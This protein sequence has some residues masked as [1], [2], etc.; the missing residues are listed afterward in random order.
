M[1]KKYNFDPTNPTNRYSFEIYDTDISIINGI[2]RVIISDIQVP[3][4]IG[5]N[6]PTVEIIKSNGPLHN[7]YLI[8]RIGLIPICLKENEID[9][10]EDN[11]IE[12]ELNVENKGTNILNVTTNDITVK[13]NNVSLNKKELNEMFYPN[14]ISNDYILI[15]RLRHNEYLHFKANVVK[16]NGKYNASFN[17]V[18]LA[19]FSY[20]ID[21]SKITKDTSI[22]DKERN[23]YTDEYGECNAVLFEIES[24]N[25]YITPK[26]LLNKSFDI[27]ISKLYNIINY[28]KTDN[29]IIN[30]YN[31]LENTYEITI[32]N[33][34]DTIGNII[35]SF[36]HN[37]FVRKNENVL[38]N[39][40]CTYCGYICPHPLKTILQIRFTLPEQTN[41]KV[42]IDFLEYNCVSIIELLQNIKSEWNIFV[43]DK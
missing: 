42:F 37:K 16:K 6:E 13:K 15:T 7:E 28:I 21:D 8:H 3:G 32:D 40:T 1:F 10:Y 39:I 29:V 30:N 35:Q 41:S 22:L 43:K 19:N 34:D 11:S 14:M 31:D 36:I 5:E 24:I 2:R 23:Y 38:N 4:I 27:L 25:K 26:Y 33:E 17:P 9:D 18:S 12:L 20:I